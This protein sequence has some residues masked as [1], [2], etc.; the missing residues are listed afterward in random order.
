MTS[1]VP[2]R[3]PAAMTAGFQE[4]RGGRQGLGVL[5]QGCIGFMGG[6]HP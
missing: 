4:G 5:E 1:K 6:L 3:S 2:A